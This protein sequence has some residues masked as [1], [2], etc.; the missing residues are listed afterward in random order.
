M[1]ENMFLST[2]IDLTKAFDT[3]NHEIIPNKLEYFWIRGHANEFFRSY[4]LNRRQYT[5]VNGIKSK[6]KCVPC[7]VPQWSVLGPLCFLYI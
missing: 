2:F 5:V 4:L 1:N 3:V 7:G 6:L